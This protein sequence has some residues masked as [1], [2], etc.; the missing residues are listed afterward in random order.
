MSTGEGFVVADPVENLVGH[1]ALTRMDL[2]FLALGL[3][4]V[5]ESRLAPLGFPLLYS[6][7]M[8][9]TGMIYLDSIPLDAAETILAVGAGGFVDPVVVRGAVESVQQTVVI[10]VAESSY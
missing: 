9:A 2:T 1:V 3:A 10:V 8:R 7:T 6:W 5:L 4:A